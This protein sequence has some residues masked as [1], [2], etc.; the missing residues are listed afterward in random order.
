M[1][2]AHEFIGLPVMDAQK[3]KRLGKAR[4]LLLDEDW[5]AVGIVLDYKALFMK[6]RYVPWQDVVAFGED[7]IMVA[8]RDCVK[9]FTRMKS[10]WHYLYMG[11]RPLAGMPVLT[12]E[13]VQLGKAQNV[14]FSQNMDNTIVGLELSDGILTDLR[15]GR[16]ILT[17]PAGTKRGEDAVTVPVYRLNEAGAGELIP[18]ERLGDAN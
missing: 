14:Y 16:K 4:D 1:R 10:G 18:Y 9:E 7:A 5:H 15:E 6:A 17:L 12:L 3:G 11:K 13:G 8:S 2:G